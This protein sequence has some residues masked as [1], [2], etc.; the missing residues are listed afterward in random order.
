M[1][2]RIILF[3]FFDL[4]VFGAT[5]DR[6]CRAQILAALYCSYLVG[7]TPQGAR[8]IGVARGEMDRRGFRETV[9]QALEEF[10]PIQFKQE[11]NSAFLECLYYTCADVYGDASWDELGQFLSEENLESGHFTCQSARACLSGSSQNCPN[12]A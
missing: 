3:R 11:K 5:S 12:T 1:V 4:T 6:S 2:A 10:M 7:L 8:I 9:R